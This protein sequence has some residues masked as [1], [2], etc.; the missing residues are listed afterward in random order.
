VASRI[1]ERTA[2]HRL[3][4]PNNPT[5]AIYPPE[6]LLAALR[7][8]PCR[9]IASIIDETYKDFREGETPVHPTFAAADWQDAFIHLYSFSKAFAMTGYRVRSRSPPCPRVL[10]EIEKIMDCMAH[11]HHAHFPACRPSH[12]PGSRGWKREKIAMM[13]GR[14]TALRHAFRRDGAWL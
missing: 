12:S 3:R 4:T 14:L 10:A 5:G 7:A 2:R 6:L 13:H 1:D 9:G 8:R 11:L